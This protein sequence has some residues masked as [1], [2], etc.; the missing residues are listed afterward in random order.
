[1]V[2]VTVIGDGKNTYF[3]KDRWM[4]GKRIKE[5]AP[6]LFAMVPKRIINTRKV[7]EALLNR[8]WITD[9]RGALSMAV[10]LDFF[11]LY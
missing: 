8:W 4:D 3:W 5:I 1:M 11:Q 10:L 2:V 7:S 9:F 6:A